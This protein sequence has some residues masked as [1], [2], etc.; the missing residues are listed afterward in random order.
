MS[1]L[2]V[3]LE[4]IVF[5]HG[6]YFDQLLSDQISPKKTKYFQKWFFVDM[7]D[8]QKRFDAEFIQKGFAWVSYLD[9]RKNKNS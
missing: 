8:N 7:D 9:G 4:N 3:W 1:E 6:Y 2:K 5:D